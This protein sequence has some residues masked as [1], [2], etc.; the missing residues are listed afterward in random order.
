M[1]KFLL[2]YPIHQALR[3]NFIHA[4]LNQQMRAALAGLMR[5]NPHLSGSFDKFV[6]GG[7]YF[8]SDR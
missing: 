1:K 2:F 3:K 5:Q 8:C 6:M 4:R 7:Q